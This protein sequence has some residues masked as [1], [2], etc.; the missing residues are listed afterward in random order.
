[1]KIPQNVKKEF[2][3][4]FDIKDD[5]VDRINEVMMQNDCAFKEIIE[6]DN[7][8]ILHDNDLLKTI[9]VCARFVNKPPMTRSELAAFIKAVTHENR[10]KFSINYDSG[11]KPKNKSIGSEIIPDN[12]NKSTKCIL[13][14]VSHKVTTTTL[15][16]VATRDS[17]IYI[18]PW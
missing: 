2:D 1:M 4:E 7:V 11:D 17:M 3:C 8:N 9:D 6:S 10:D 14:A 5:V 15:Q 18:V 16:H 13:L 12:N